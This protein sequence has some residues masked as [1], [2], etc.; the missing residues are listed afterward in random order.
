M[1]DVCKYSYFN[2]AKWTYGD[3]FNIAIGQGDNAYTPLQMASYVATLGNGG[4]K[5]Q[6]S[7][8]KGIEGEGQRK[9]K[10]ATQIDVSESDLEHVL[11][12]M[13]LVAKRGTLAGTFGSF[14]IAVAGKTGTAQ[15]DGYINPK[16]EVAY[17]KSHL[18]SIA[19]GI[20]WS[21]VEKMM[22]KLMKEDPK[23]YPTE[24]DTVDAALIKVSNK[25]VTYA[26]IN[27][28]KDTYDHFAW[29]ITLAPADN[30][31]I[32]VVVLLV[33]GGVSFNAA[34]I[35]REIIGDYLQVDTTTQALDFSTKMN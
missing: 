12:G 19:P 18:G 17:V 8:I 32:A 16:D 10:K 26:K 22:T 24:N 1:T 5:N 35:A 20:S 25:K 6:V 34:P 28:F 7:I 29:T 14:P 15:R 2:Q 33:Q 3:E 13:R 27:Q 31:Q 11:E 21:Q 23:K 4:K 30:P 9:K